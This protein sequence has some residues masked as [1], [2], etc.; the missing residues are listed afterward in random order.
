MQMV[1]L[2]L[3]RVVIVALPF[4]VIHGCSTSGRN[5]LVHAKKLPEKRENRNFGEIFCAIKAGLE[6]RQRPKRTEH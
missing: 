3:Q 4:A 1:F 5:H 6:E 2:Y